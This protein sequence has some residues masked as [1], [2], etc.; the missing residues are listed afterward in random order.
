MAMKRIEGSR[1]G[2]SN[3]L[4]LE[5]QSELFFLYVLQLYDC[6]FNKQWIRG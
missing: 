3:L 5:G 2:I 4:E 6:A 1:A